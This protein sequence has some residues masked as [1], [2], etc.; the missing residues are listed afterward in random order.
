[1]EE[2]LRYRPHLIH[3]S[4]HGDALG[5]L[6]ADD[7]PMGGKNFSGLLL[8]Y[9]SS[10]GEDLR[11]ALLNACWAASAARALAKAGLLA[12]GWSAEVDDKPAVAFSRA[13]Y[14]A[15]ANGR[16][17]PASANIEACGRLAYAQ[18]KVEGLTLPELKVSSPENAPSA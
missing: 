15:L 10:G 8:A 7:Q 13:F 6:L 5:R 16:E 4:G 2:L 1:M 9:R 17:P 18:V 14:V 3:F 12:I 11:A